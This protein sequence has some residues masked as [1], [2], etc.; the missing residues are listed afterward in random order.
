LY[1]SLNNNTKQPHSFLGCCPS[2]YTTLNRDTWYLN[3]TYTLIM[4]TAFLSATLAIV[5]SVSALPAPQE[6]PTTKIVKPLPLNIF[7]DTPKFVQPVPLEEAK[8]IFQEHNA[9][10]PEQPEASFRITTFAAA[11]TCAN[12]RVRIEWDSYP[13]SSKQAFVDAIKC[14]MGRAPSGQFRASRSRY[15]DLVALH[16]TLTPNVHG[17]SKFLLWHR[18]YT[19]VFEDI[20]R[21]ECGF[22]QAMPWFDETRYAGRF[23]QSSIFSSRWLGAIALGGN[24]VT[25]GVST[26]PLSD[27]PPVSK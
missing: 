9:T 25:N 11:A 17:S 8:K 3:N 12:P 16:Q 2:L 26:T 1:S 23:S 18:Y 27:A 20:L 14:L 24:C 19:W 10:Q 21:A 13:D 22:N 7:A 6:L 4:R 5:A 15:E